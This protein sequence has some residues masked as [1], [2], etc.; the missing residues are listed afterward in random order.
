MVFL[1]DFE[2]SLRPPAK[3]ETKQTDGRKSVRKTRL[4]K[5][6]TEVHTSDGY[7]DEGTGT[8]IDVT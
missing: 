8:E 6:H 2:E 7:G 4:K 5:I 3:V 1:I